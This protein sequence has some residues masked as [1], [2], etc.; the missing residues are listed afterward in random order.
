MTDTTENASR[1]LI[2]SML[3]IGS[4]QV[5]NILISITR[6]K[7][8]A[9]LLGPAGVGVLSIYTN[10]Q[11]TAGAVAGLGLET[12]GVREIA[13]V[14]GKEPALSR[15][16]VVLFTGNLVQG[17]LAMGLIWL[18]RA[19]L[20]VWLFTDPTHATETGLVGIAVV[21]ALLASSQ[22]ALLQGMRRIGD[23]GRVRVLGALGGAVAGLFAVWMVGE[24]GLIWFVIVQPLASVL[25]A[26]RFTLKLPRPTVKRL[27]LGQIWP[28]WRSMASLG[29]VFMLGGL[30]TT[31]TL[32]L[33]RGMIARETG[34]EGVGL[35]SASWGITMQYVGF[36]LGAMAADYYPRLTEVINDRPAAHRLINDQ[37][38]LAMALG[39]PV[40]LLLIGLAP[41]V[42]TLLYSSE[43]SEAAGILQWQTVGN[44]FKLASWPLGFVFIAAAQSRMFFFTEILWNA[45]FL[46]FVWAGLPFFGLKV[47]GWAFLLAY[48]MYLVIL[49]FVVRAQHGFHWEP[50]SVKLIGA[51]T[52]LCLTLL[53]IATS[54]PLSGAIIGISTSALT[55]LLG[56]RIVLIKVGL[57]GRLAKTLAKG[58]AAIGWRIE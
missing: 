48:A 22:T 54:A 47:T 26:L 25:V 58:F 56:L 53:A 10:L 24:S 1:G 17:L 37:V 51:Y 42:M 30:A 16:R 14:K 52:V 8:V 5:V 34:L 44:I 35:F 45:L 11:G 12:S 41:W 38:Q 23:L 13:S 32:L 2:R 33:V 6:M 3:I 7:L 20:S 46:G 19:Q 50:L 40:L 49:H 55:G 29:F 57:G 31:G 15:V 18:F 36:L 28:I 4:A 21:L 39:G 9:L 27:T 43:F